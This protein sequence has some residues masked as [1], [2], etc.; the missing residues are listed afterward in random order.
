M[1]V[2]FSPGEAETRPLNP[3]EIVYTTA[4]KVAD[5]LGI[6]P[7]EA[8]LAGHD[9]DTNGVYVTGADYRDHGFQSGDTILVY[10]DDDPMGIEKKISTPTTSV[11]G[12]KLPFETG[13]VTAATYTVAKNTYIQNTASFTNGKTRGVKK[14]HVEQ[15]IKEIQDRIDNIT[16]N[17]WRPTLVSAEYINFDTYKPYR[18]RYY[19]DYV[20]TTPLL[21]RNVQQ[22]LRLELWQGDDYREIGAAEARLEIVDEEEL[23]GDSI[24]VGMTNGSVATLSVGTGSNNW[25]ADFDK[26]STAQNL[27][28]LINKEDRV[29]KTVVEFSPTFTLEGSSSNIGVHNEVLASANADYGNGH[30]KLTSMRQTKGGENT[31]IASTDLTNLTISQIGS[32]STK[33]ANGYFSSALTGFN[34]YVEVAMYPAAD[35]HMIVHGFLS[36]STIIVLHSLSPDPSTIFTTGQVV[37]NENREEVGTISSFGGGSGSYQIVFTATVTN[38][39]TTEYLYDFKVIN[40]VNTDTAAAA[41]VSNLGYLASDSSPIYLADGTIYG[42]VVA[43]AD[44]GAARIHFSSPVEK[45]AINTKLYNR[46]VIKVTGSASHT[47]TAGETIHQSDGTLLGTFASTE[48]TAHATLFRL[49]DTSTVVPVYTDLL[50]HEAVR[51]DT[52]ST[53]ITVSETSNFPSK[54]ILMIVNGANTRVFKYTGKTATTFTG[55]AVLGGGAALTQLDTVGTEIT[56]YFFQSDIGAQ[57]TQTTTVVDNGVETIV[58]QSGV[59]A[60]KRLGDWWIDHE[61]GIIYFNNSYPFFEWNAVKVSYIYGERYLEK[62]IEEAA[63]KFVA[64]DL[65]MADD[66]SVLIPE[67]SQNVPLAQKIQMFKEEANS[68]L[69]RYKEIVLFE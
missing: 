65:L 15:R 46:K 22:I 9:S 61:M 45:L 27:A 41:P 33:T 12:V 51:D 2:V 35:A 19:T 36:S 54:G 26:V 30:L 67:G 69:N 13:T 4:Q 57:S 5:L 60:Q 31:M 68:L 42:T 24:Y 62:A 47:F 7:G 55:V 8:V 23:A 48:T 56:Q 53:T 37:Y 40:T 58:R 18:R 38:I 44:T 1:P 34:N 3:E 32:R 52:S 20:G 25:R 16:H 28:D 66:R 10:S 59:G 49:S 21:Y 17:A 43:A 50:Y 6:G 39:S 14:S 11:N 29:S 63:T 64:V